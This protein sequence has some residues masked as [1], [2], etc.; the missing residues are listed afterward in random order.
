MGGK[1]YL[2]GLV[3]LLLISSFCLAEEEK[4]EEPTET[5]P[6]TVDEDVGKSRDGSKTDDEAVQR[7]EEAIKLDGLNVAQMKELREKAEKHTFQ[8]EVSRMMK[9][10]INSLYRNKEIFLRELISNSSDALDK[11]RFLSLT[12][13]SAL[14]A[15][16]ELSIKIKADKENNILHV[17]DTGI[18][19]TKDD[20]VKNLGTIAKSGTS[21]FFQKMADAQSSD[22]ASDLIGQFGVGFYSTFLVA[23]RVIVTSKHND[24]KQYIWE[25]DAA[26]FSITEDPRGDTLKRGTTVSLHLKEEARDFLEPDTIKDLVKKYSQFIN[27]NI[28]LWTS[29]TEE[30][31][32]PIEEEAAED[33]KAD[34][35]AEDKK[36]EEKEEE[37]KDEDKEKEDKDDDAEVE[38]ESEE[39]EKKPKTKK[40]EKTTWD[41]ELI[42]TNKPIWSRK[43]K[44]V[45]DEEY[46]E[47]YKSFTKDHDEPLAKTHFVAEGEVT[48]R[49]IL[50][51]PK[52]APNNLFSEYGKKMDQIKLYVRRVFITD[53][54]EDMMPKYLSFIRG[55]VDSDD[56]PLNVSRENLQQHKLL[57][58]IKKKLVRKALDMIKKI[59]KEEYMD[60]FWKEFSTSIKL[61]VMED[62]SNRTRLAKLL[63][64]FSSNSEKDMTSLADYLERM[65]EKQDAIYFM[66]GTSR[67]EVESSPFVERLLKKGYEVLYL[68]EPVDEY[69][70]QSLPEFEGKKFQ[71]V[72]K[73]GLKIGEESE[74]QKKKL[75]ALEST[76]EPLLKWLKEDALKDLIEKAAISQRLDESPCALVA[77][78]YGWSGN[79][80][81]IMRSQAYAKR[82]DPS[83]EYYANQKRTLEVNPRHPLVKELLKRVET[84]KE[85]KTAKDLARVL[86]ETAT[87]RSGYM[88]KDSQDFAGRIERMLRLSMGVDLEAMVEPEEEEAEEKEEED[89]DTEE[90]DA[91]GDKDEEK[92]EEESAASE[93]TPSEG[94]T[95]TEE[96]EDE[97]EGESKE[98]PAE[99]KD[100]L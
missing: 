91:E 5:E 8:A 28:Y 61:G 65:K 57:K 84:D 97:V 14:A 46:N 75:E 78:S 92:T 13:K 11:I 63:R 58:V 17:T 96:K 12:D 23:D 53:N 99:A 16:E 41:W 42:N 19:M 62:H 43:P 67:K 20:L 26:S 54:F 3:G 87:L 98:A 59:P 44:D 39:K 2:L 49:S 51:V 72:A 95:K 45:K 55:V 47:F 15:T 38:E 27:F 76:Y 93:E 86:F 77:S 60:K 82:E 48:F 70:I 35:A 4:T 21:E 36:D 22:Q 90:V 6:P 52:S 24:D 94:E 25:S 88:V 32:E 80:E 29:K 30:V 68:I 33:K 64:F 50:Y 74:K 1:S 83:N 100:E 89:K 56:L 18:G 69:C 66:A 34:E 81:R 73:E 71:N 10:I 7:E 85:D 37:K 31:E 40:V 79:M 9:L